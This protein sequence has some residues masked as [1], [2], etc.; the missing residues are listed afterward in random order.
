MSLHY[1]VKYL[2]SK[3]CHAQKV[4]EAN[5][6]VRLRHSKSSF[7]YL[8]DKNIYYY[9]L[10]NSVTKKR[11]RRTYK[12]SHYRLYTTAVTK[13]KMLQQNAVHYQQ[14]VSY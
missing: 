13:K 7:K 8:S 9:L 4:I 11:P 10:F 2:C 3:N 14:S 6:H 1:L 12:K 5:C